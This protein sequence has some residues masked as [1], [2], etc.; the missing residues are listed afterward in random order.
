MKYEQE[1]GK[2]KL[3][4]QLWDHHENR[5]TYSFIIRDYERQQA[6][7]TQTEEM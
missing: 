7:K 1:R 6:K 2:K 3:V 4:K 5:F